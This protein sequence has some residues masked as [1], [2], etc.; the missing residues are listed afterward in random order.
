MI[1]FTGL[2]SVGFLNRVLKTHHWVGMFSVILG[3]SIVG[4]SDFVCNGGQHQ[5]DYSK[6]RI[7]TGLCKCRKIHSYEQHAD[8]I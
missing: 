2:L 3:L 4:I 7:I 6:N 1:I 8:K 5:F